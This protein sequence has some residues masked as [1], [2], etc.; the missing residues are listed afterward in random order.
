MVAIVS[1]RSRQESWLLA[2]F[3][4]DAQPCPCQANGGSTFAQDAE[5]LGKIH[6]YNLVTA[7]FPGADGSE[8][9][10]FANG[11][12]VG[13]FGF[14]GPQIQSFTF[15]GGQYKVFDVPGA[16]ATLF[17][18]GSAAADLN[19]DG[20]VDLAL[21]NG[22]SFD[23]G[24]IAVLHNLPVI[25]VFPNTLNFGKEKVGVKCNPLTITI[26][27]RAA[28][29]LLS[30]VTRKLVEPTPPTLPKPPPAP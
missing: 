19:G 5:P 22:S 24:S 3:G 1:P 30:A 15:H 6:A 21:S 18:S 7:D 20:G 8:A 13:T 28:R 17:P 29:R 2:K 27:K 4:D 11:T 26:S 16:T 14:F 10:G 12:T 23:S 25:S 9:F